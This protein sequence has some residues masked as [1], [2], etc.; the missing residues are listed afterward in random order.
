MTTF[1][2][3]MYMYTAFGTVFTSN[4]KKIDHQSMTCLAI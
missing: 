1:N 4:Q 3:Y 2:T